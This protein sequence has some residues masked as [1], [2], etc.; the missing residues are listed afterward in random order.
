MEPVQVSCRGKHTALKSL[1]FD[2][3][4]PGLIYAGTHDGDILLFDTRERLPEDKLQ[5]SFLRK[6]SA[7]KP[8]KRAQI[9]GV[10][11]LICMSC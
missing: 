2:V 1:A 3:N 4:L 11:Q 5:F 9:E 6:I 10:C 7:K 8:G